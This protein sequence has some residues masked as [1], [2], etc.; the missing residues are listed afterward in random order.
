MQAKNIFI[1]FALLAFSLQS[2]SAQTVIKPT[3]KPTKS[4]QVKNQQTVYQLKHARAE[5][6][7]KL[8]THTIP[9]FKILADSRTNSVIVSGPAN[10]KASIKLIEDWINATDK[11]SPA[12]QMIKAFTL[13]NVSAA[14][15]QA[16]VTDLFGVEKAA[17][18][19]SSD[20]RT[21][22]LIAVGSEDALKTVETILLSLDVSPA[23]QPN[24]VTQFVPAQK[25][26]RVMSQVVA[27][28]ARDLEVDMVHDE[29]RDYVVVRGTQSAVDEVAAM[30]QTVGQMAHAKSNDDAKRQ[31]QPTGTLRVIWLMTGKGK[32]LPQELKSV[33][34]ALAK[35]GVENLG[36]MSQMMV[37]GTDSNFAVEGE[38]SDA[39]L[40]VS[41]E[42]NATDGQHTSFDLDIQ[43]EALKQSNG[44][45][46]SSA[47]VSTTVRLSA[48]QLV[49]LGVAPANDEQ[50]VFVVQLV[51][52]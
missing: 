26:D 12:A 29:L 24:T 36:F 30:I 4:V 44:S 43:V 40:R 47:N 42:R 39:A 10:A 8:L 34:V 3:K 13:Q 41:G 23:K 27:M 46:G 14:E 15:A 6:I 37:N 9:D 35:I 51:K 17:I 1:T 11:A 20:P 21:N 32:E 52:P 50:S 16:A 5:P 7:A 45:R 38:T 22:S 2:A 18:R 48:G 31:S 49:V 19:F 28:A 25:F 33:A